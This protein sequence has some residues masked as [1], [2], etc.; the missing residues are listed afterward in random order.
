MIVHVELAACKAGLV[1]IGFL[2]LF[3]IYFMHLNIS[4]CLSEMV[5]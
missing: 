3:L 1:M 4:F 5:L 2:F